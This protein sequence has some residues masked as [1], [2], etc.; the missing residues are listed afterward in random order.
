MKWLKFHEIE[1]S[2]QIAIK[3]NIQK[4]F[5]TLNPTAFLGTKTV[6]KLSKIMK[7]EV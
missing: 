3:N 1:F 6:R 4:Q 7:L 5:K 2:A